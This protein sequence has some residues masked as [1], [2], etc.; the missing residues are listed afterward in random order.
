MSDDANKESQGIDPQWL[1]DRLKRHFSE[2]TRLA[3]PAVMMRIGIFGLAMV[4]TAMVGHYATEHL[5]WLNLANQS[6]IMFALVVGLGLLGGITVYTANAIG[7]DDHREAG[8]V[9][10]RNMPFALGVGLLLLLSVWPAEYWLSFLGQPAD[11]AFEGGKL[12]RILAIGLPGHMLFVCCVAF[13]EG[14]K[15]A[16]VGVYLMIGA[17][18]V[19]LILNYALI[20]GHWG[21]P[22]MGAEGSAW[23]STGVRWFMAVTAVG[24]VWLAP[25]VRGFGLRKPHGQKWSD[26]RDQRQMGYASAVSLAAEVLA[27]GALAIF[28]GWIGTVPLAAHGVVFQVVG[29]PLMISI[30]IGVAS[31]V[32]VGI[33]FSRRDKADTALA[34]ISGILLNFL[35]CGLF[36]IVIIFNIE[37]LL[38]IFTDDA[39]VLAILVPPVVIY[40]IAMVFDASQ[41]VASM[42]L[43]G[44]RE[45]W[46]PTYLQ[47]FAFILVMLP[48]CYIMAFPV[49]HGW[50]GLMEGMGIGVV[51]SWILQILRFQYLAR[52]RL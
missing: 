50:A 41:M 39:R 8:R 33:A 37:P 14:V 7:A 46:W 30:G 3:L 38:G 29:I 49:G 19:N 9:W 27:F 17:N 42:I 16:E 12:I 5:A 13:L 6:V 21:M 40:A 36:A 23:A 11:K 32:R 35:L 34:G 10:R 28:A 22:E 24:Y 18:I 48:A 52:H 51:T 25:S 2:L 45:T 43:R 44:Y 1:R 15:R 26:W 31:S 4:D 47:G 20:F